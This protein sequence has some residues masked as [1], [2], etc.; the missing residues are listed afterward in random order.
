MA[1]GQP[2]FDQVNLVARDLDATLTCYRRLG[3]DL[4]DARVW[5]TASGAHHAEV[6][7]PNGVALEL[8][9]EAMARHYDAGR[10][11]AGASGQR[12]VIG[13]KLSTREAVDAR[14]AA[15]GGRLRRPATA[16]RRLLGGALCDCR[17]PRRHARRPDEP[18]R[19]DAPRRA[20]AALTQRRRAA[21]VRMV[22]LARVCRARHKLAV[23][24]R[25]SDGAARP[26]LCWRRRG[27][28]AAARTVAA[29]RRHAWRCWARF[30]PSWRPSWRRRRWR[31]RWSSKGAPSAPGASARCRW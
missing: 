13:F 22:A 24:G 16:L 27:S 2:L 4:D 5:R 14:Y 15:D 1:N 9:S 20:A 12:A 6:R 25:A 30:Q 10:R 11:A 23:W 8:D 29:P 7:M 3:L 21:V 17:G 26:R 28:P 31:R 18:G 19:P